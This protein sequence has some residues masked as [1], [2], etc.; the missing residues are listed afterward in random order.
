MFYFSLGSI[1]VAG[2]PST[3]NVDSVPSTALTCDGSA[4]DTNLGMPSSVNG[5]VL[6]GQCTTHGTYVDAGGDTTDTAGGSSAP[7]TRGLLFFVGHA[8]VL[9]PTFAANNGM[10]FSGALY[11]HNA[12][13]LDVVPFTAGGLGGLGGLLGGSSGT[14]IY[15]LGPMVVDQ[16]TIAASTQVNVGLSATSKQYLTK[17]GLI[18]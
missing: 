11:F 15:V 16:L 4:P 18:G 1:D 10:V 12:L 5:I 17:A 2:S 13:Y 9:P 14:G 6:L 7:G 8:N 3:T